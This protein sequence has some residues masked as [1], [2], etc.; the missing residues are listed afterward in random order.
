MEKPFE[1]VRVAGQEVELTREN[2]RLF[3]HLGRAAMFDHVFIETNVGAYQ[4]RYD[5]QSGEDLEQYHHLKE[6]VIENQCPLHLN[7]Q[8]PYDIDV[9][10]YMQHA[11]VDWDTVAFDE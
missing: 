11:K 3:T 9:K 2:T 8:E 7:L 5:P 10:V 1:T 6:K 4:W